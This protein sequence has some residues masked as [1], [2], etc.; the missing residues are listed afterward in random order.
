MRAMLNAQVS[1]RMSVWGGVCVAHLCRTK[2]AVSHLETPL[3]S[4]PCFPSM[5]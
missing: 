2:M 1:F 3:G 5:S 4:L